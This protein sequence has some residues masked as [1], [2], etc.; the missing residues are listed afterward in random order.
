METVDLRKNLMQSI[1]TLPSDM[2]EELNKFVNFLKYKNL[3]E[4][5]ELSDY[6]QTP[7]FQKDKK[8]IQSTYK[9]VINGEANLLTK[10]EYDEKMNE[11]VADLKLR[12]AN[13]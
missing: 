1:D 3:S 5:D 4:Q 7:Q 12:Y 11:F 2:L 13:S 10:E 6:L 8:K 9:D